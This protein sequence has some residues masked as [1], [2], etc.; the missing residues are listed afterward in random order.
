VAV[1]DFPTGGEG[2]NAA[3]ECGVQGAVISS[4][5]Y[6][7][8]L[9]LTKGHPD[10]TTVT[11]GLEAVLNENI[12]NGIVVTSDI[13]TSKEVAACDVTICSVRINYSA[14][15]KTPSKHEDIDMVE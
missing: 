13:A 12:T 6:W 2:R 8:I 15:A 1:A 9:V 4:L 5:L 11:I 7:S 3:F 10:P 14:F